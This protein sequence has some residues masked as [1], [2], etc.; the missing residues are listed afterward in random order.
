MK[1]MNIIKYIGSAVL[2]ALLS[3]AAFAGTTH[4]EYG[5]I[6]NASDG[7]TASGAA[8]RLYKASLPA[9]LV[10]GTAMAKP[11][12]LTGFFWALDAGFL[13][14]T[15]WMPGDDHMTLIDKETN[16]GTATH[17]GYYAVINKNVTSY[18]PDQFNDVT[19]RQIPV[20]TGTAA[21]SSAMLSWSAAIA[22]VGT[23]DRSATNIAGYNLYRST[24]QTGP[25]TKVNTSL[26]TGTS[27]VDTGLTNGTTYYYVLKLVYRV[28]AGTALMSQY[29]SAN[30][31]GIT[32]GGVIPPSDKMIDDYE[33]HVNRDPRG[34]MDYYYQSGANAGEVTIAN[35]ANDLASY[36]EGARSMMTVYP[37]AGAGQWGGYWGGGFNNPAVDAVDVSAHNMLVYYLKGDGTDN[38]VRAAFNEYKNGTQ[39]EDFRALDSIPMSGTAGYEE[40]KIPYT[41]LW[42]DEFSPVKDDNVFSQSVKGYTFVFRGA[43][44]S[45]NQH[46]IDY[47]KATLWSGPIIDLIGPSYGPTGTT[48][49]LIGRNFGSVQGASTVT[50]NGIAAAVTSWTSTRIVTIVP[51]AATT[52]LVFV[53]V[54]GQKSNGVNFTVTTSAGP[55]I[56][57]LTPSSGPIGTLV[58][59]NGSGF[60]ADPGAG[61]RATAANHIVMG[62]AKILDADV[63]SWSDTAI[64]YRVPSL[65]N[66][67]YPVQVRANDLESNIVNFTVTSGG[68][69]PTVTGI[70]PNTGPNNTT[71]AITISGTNFTGATLVKIGTTSIPFTVVNSTTITATVPSGLVPGPYN[72]TVTT[73]SGTSATG[74]A[75]V[76][77]VTLPSV[78]KLLDDYETHA[79]RDPLGSMDYYYTS[80]AG[81]GEVTIPALL[82]DLVAKQ[83]GL[84]SMQIQYPG[85][86]TGQWGGYWGGGFTNPA[87]DAVDVTGYNMLV[88]YLKGDG[89]INELSP[90]LAEYKNGTQDE[91]FRALDSMTL[92]GTAAFKM[93]KIPF[94]R[95]WIDEYSAVKDDLSFSN[96]VKGY[97]FVYKGAGAT[98]A[99]NNVDWLKVTM[100]GG[101]IIDLI[102]PSYGPVGTTTVIYGS[103]FGATKGS[104][105]LTFNGIPATTSS[106]SSNIIVAT[107]PAGAVTGPVE[108]T[109]GGQVSNAVLFTVTTNSG[110]VITSLV[111]N[112][113]APGSTFTI[114]GTGFG[115]DPGAGN[116]ATAANHVVMGPAKIQESQITAWSDTAI[117]LKVPSLPNGVYPV[118]VRA[119]NL[120]SNLVNF[121]VATGTLPV[122]AAI[123]PK[124]GSNRAT[125]PIAITGT[126]FTGVTAVRI[127]TWP[128]SS[129]IVTSPTRIDA[130]IQ[131]GLPI[132]KYYVTVTTPNGTSATGPANEFTVTNAPVDDNAPEIKDVRFDSKLVNAGDY[133]SKKPKIRAMIIDDIA[134]DADTI[135]VR[136]A[137][138]TYDKLSAPSVS[139][140]PSSKIMELQLTDEITTGDVEAIINAKDTSGNPAE[141]RV[142]LKVSDGGDIDGRIINYPNPFDPNHEETKI[143]F[144][145]KSDMKIDIYIF[146]STGRIIAKKMC[147][148]KIGYNE[149][150]WN[151][152]D[153]FGSI[154]ANGVYPSRLLSGGKVLG[155][156]KIWVVK[157]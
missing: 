138:S 107:V 53:T 157:K 130:V 77:T 83:E 58:T 51:A 41:R 117:I 28:T 37:G 101:P 25:F 27:Y 121:T 141:Y 21:P 40:V 104:S 13:L 3:T 146:D 31:A 24:S 76:F 124:T 14:N 149:V 23:P 116:R 35:P 135:T 4:T 1:N 11:S 36:H 105:V 142:R 74:P 34:H 62:T 54:G 86:A 129:Y 127:E 102:G 113:G 60:G 145:L 94:S 20:P 136:L 103:G 126:G 6:N 68:N 15:Q 91:T 63:I 70:N 75:S 57:S 118:Q 150:I 137:G 100:W 12:P 59:I 2:A 29:Y 96:K 46:N 106:W 48:V 89:T 73:P 16:S 49:T 22:D 153:D 9:E 10:T 133:I 66:G 144:N 80:G 67:V 152:R 81:A 143:A 69:V 95:I 110:P 26:I 99:N 115:A 30:S 42:R 155:K 55:V 64:Q 50:F 112:T 17:K 8:V 111:P 85:A 33:N 71:T 32:P 39:D 18:D 65:A 7:T 119:N 97:T 156:L 79:G 47:V 128:V 109:V 44:T 84:R 88:Y 114:N 87:L 148:G 125:T 108:V 45:A 61:N 93:V 78:D 82:N 43:V 131:S 38:S 122:V 132:G 56:T 19:L 123:D 147:D 5:S 139:Y 98:T 151:G 120:E 92:T 90:S 134:I 140:D 72:V 52:G 154:A